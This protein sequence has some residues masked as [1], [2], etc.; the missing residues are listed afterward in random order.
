[1]SPALSRDMNFGTFAYGMAA[2]FFALG[3]FELSAMVEWG[4]GLGPGWSSSPMAALNTR[5]IRC[6]TRRAVSGFS[7][8]IGDNAFLI[9]GASILSM[10]C[11][12][13]IGNT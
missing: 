13:M 10:G 7:L 3:R 2:K 5:P 4:V 8:Q 1:M 9:A 12:P 11:A 6:F